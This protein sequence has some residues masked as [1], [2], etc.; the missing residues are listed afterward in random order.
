MYYANLCA[1]IKFVFLIPIK[2]CRVP[3]SLKNKPLQNG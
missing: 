2:Q 1:S 3:L